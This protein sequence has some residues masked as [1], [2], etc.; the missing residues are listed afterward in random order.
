MPPMDPTPVS[1]RQLLPTGEARA[2]LR[3]WRNFKDRGSKYLIACAGIGVVVALATI[4]VY[5]FS[6]V[7]PMLRPASVDPVE[8]YAAPGG[9]G[10]TVFLATERYR[11]VGVRFT[12]DARAVFFELDGG[13]VREAHDLPLPD[14]VSVTA[15]AAA[16]PRTG[17]VAYGLSDGTA[18]A[19]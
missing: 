8:S 5:L 16:E 13:T 15:F 17:L 1:A 2:R 7:M 19:A 14:G 10:E 11:E 9:E 18:C 3:R 6:E 4:F 12:R